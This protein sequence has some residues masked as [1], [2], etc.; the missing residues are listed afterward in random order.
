MLIVKKKNQSV[1]AY[2]W[3][4]LGIRGSF[5]LVGPPWRIVCLKYSD[6]E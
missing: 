1:E 2:N 3:G 4:I 6:S 5:G